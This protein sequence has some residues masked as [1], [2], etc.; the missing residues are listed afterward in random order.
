MTAFPQSDR[1]ASP[2]LHVT[3][4]FTIG[5][6]IAVLVMS[7]IFKV[8]VVARGQGRIVPISRVQIIQPEFPGRI[9]A[10]YVRNGTSVAQGDRLIAF[11]P[12]DARAELGK[13]QSERERLKIETARIEAVVATLDH[14]PDSEGFL[15]SGLSRFVLPE[16]LSS[17]PFAVEQSRLLEAE[18]KD[19]L[20]SFAQIQAREEANRKSEA[21]THANVDRVTAAIGFQLERLR[22]AERLHRQGTVTRS[23]LL[24]AQQAFAEL[25]RQRMVYLREL[26][27]KAAERKALDSERRRITADL[28]SRMLDRKAEISA[29]LAILEEEMRTA[30]RRLAATT[31]TA[32]VSGVV[33]RLSVF[34]IGGVTEAGAE[35]LRICLLYTSPSPRD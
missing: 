6:F 23:A 18:I 16:A 1:V 21:V 17:H 34:T 15:D 22:T 28:R 2:T 5:V 30:T 32:P 3:I 20:A 33:D 4:F 10:L 14:D 9:A 13:V 27:Q 8:E 31:L 29:R 24:D 19:L 12:T 35:L 7:F 25:E 11:D 26:D